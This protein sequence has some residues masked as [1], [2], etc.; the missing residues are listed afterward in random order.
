MT[1]F[2]DGP[3]G[4]IAYDYVYGLSDLPPLVFLCGFKSDMQ[5]SKAQWLHEYCI[6]NNRSYL[7]FD[8]FAHGQSDGDFMAY[9]I[10][11]GLIDTLFMMDEFIKTPAIIIGSSM[12]GWIGLRLMQFMPHKMHGF[13]GI[14]AAPDFTRKI[15]AQLDDGHLR[16]L[17]EKGYMEEPSDY[18]EPYIFTKALFDDGENQCILGQ[19]IEFDGDIHLLQGKLDTSVDWHTPE[20]INACFDGKAKITLID[21]GDHSLSRLQDLEILKQVIEQMSS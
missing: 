12:G 8:Y 9:T 7:R 21:D 20:E 18:G 15:Y 1:S 11:K 13:I 16:Q 3:N 6:A 5:G 4:K 17:E 19:N 10:G 2:I 14:A